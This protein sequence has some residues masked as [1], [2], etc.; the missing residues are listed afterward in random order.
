MNRILVHLFP[1]PSHTDSSSSR[2]LASLRVFG[3]V[4][5]G[6][7]LLRLDAGAAVPATDGGLR[8]NG[9]HCGLHRRSR[10]QYLFIAFRIQLASNGMVNSV[11]YGY[12]LTD[13]F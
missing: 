3:R 1:A 8:K 6:A 4:L 5:R 9:L 2:R 10:C 12:L 7:D 13:L 11:E